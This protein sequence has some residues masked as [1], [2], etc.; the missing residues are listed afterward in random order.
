MMAYNILLREKD[1][2]LI[3]QALYAYV[4]LDN[5]RDQKKSEDIKWLVKHLEGEIND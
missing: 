5:D 4:I 3:I 2:E 1:I